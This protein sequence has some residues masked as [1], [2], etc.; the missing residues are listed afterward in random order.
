MSREWKYKIGRDKTSV[1]LMFL[2]STL[3]GSLTVWLHRTNNGAFIFTAMLTAVMVL[4]LLL[5]IHSFFFYKVLIGEDGFYYQTNIGNGKYYAYRDVEKAWIS[6]GTAQN[7]GQ[8]DFCNIAVHGQSA[9]RFQFLY[10]D[11]KAVKYLVNCVNTATGRIKTDS[12]DEKDEYLIDGK[13]FGK[14]KIGI[15]IIVIAILVFIDAFLVN[16]IGISFILI[17]NVAMG[18]AIAWFLFNDYLFYR[19]KIGKDGFYCRTNPFDGQYY[20]YEEIISCGEIKK[21]VRFY[22]HGHG[23]IHPTYYFYFEFTDVLGKTRKFLFEKSIYEHEV[24]VLK[25]RIEKAQ[26]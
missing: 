26:D 14:T 16:E 9:I 21:V 2:M 17:P 15:G 22:H 8:Q 11:E 5:T 13:T 10:N 20:K 25:E 4:V 19:I 3:F 18:I 7:G 23:S 24:N 6:S 1:V 12:A